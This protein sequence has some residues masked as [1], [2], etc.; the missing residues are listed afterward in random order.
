[1]LRARGVAEGALRVTSSDWP[2][3]QKPRKIG[4]MAD[5]SRVATCPRIGYIAATINLGAVGNE[6]DRREGLQWFAAGARSARATGL[7]ALPAVRD[8]RHPRH[9]VRQAG[10]QL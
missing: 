5:A 3:S 9:V 4:H 2:H 10:H 8:R 6:L 1:M 7:P